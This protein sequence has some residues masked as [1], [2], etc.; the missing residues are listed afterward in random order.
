ML[1]ARFGPRTATRAFSSY[2]S[3]HQETPL[4]YYRA[5]QHATSSINHRLAYV[6]AVF[7]IW[8]CD[9]LNAILDW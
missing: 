2:K 3:A 8:V 5:T 9:S 7:V 4:T 6:N 1:F